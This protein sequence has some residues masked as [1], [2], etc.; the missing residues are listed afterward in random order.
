MGILFGVFVGVLVDD[1][2]AVV[3]GTTVTPTGV[4]AVS[5][6]GRVETSVVGCVV[7]C[8]VSV[9]VSV[10]TRAVVG[11]VVG[12]SVMDCVVT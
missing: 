2:G 1:S 4:V 5:V 8:G 9:V 12:T 3:S 7:I 11:R 10:V 6:V